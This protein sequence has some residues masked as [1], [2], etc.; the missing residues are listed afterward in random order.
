MIVPPAHSRNTHSKF[1][2]L[3]AIT[4]NSRRS[5]ASVGKPRLARGQEGKVMKRLLSACA[6]LAMLVGSASAQLSDAGDPETLAREIANADPNP[7]P[8]TGDPWEGFNRRMFALNNQFDENVLVP[9]AKVYRATTHK[10]QR[11]GVRNFL[12]NARTPVILVNDLLQGEI[13]RAGDTAKRFAINS[14][15]GFGGMGDPAERMGIAQHSEDF[16][17]TLAI[18]GAPSGPFVVLPFF[19]P[20]TV[21]DGVGAGVDT[22]ID[23]LNWVRTDSAQLTRFVRTGTTIISAREPLIEPINDIKATSL[24]YYASFRSFYLQSRQR[25]IAN[26]RTNFEDLPDIG[27]FEE[28]DEIE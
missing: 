20:S 11:K 16:G 6:G 14:T 4:L 28:F 7:A 9:I 17:Q 22:A 19:G 18:W 15:I 21:R 23:P 25:E 3:I 12:A 8:V 2:D 5:R 27:D 26:G 10:K 13:S 1:E 24:D